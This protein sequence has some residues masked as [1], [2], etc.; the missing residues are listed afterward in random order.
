MGSK[1]S[2]PQKVSSTELGQLIG[3]V[4]LQ[5]IELVS[6]TFRADKARMEGLSNGLEMGT[7]IRCQVKAIGQGHFY[8][9]VSAVIGS[10]SKKES[11]DLPFVGE[12][13]WS[14]LYRT[15][16]QHPQAVIEAFVANSSLLHAWPYIREFTHSMTA[17]MG[18]PPLVL[19]LLVITQGPSQAPQVPPKTPSE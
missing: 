11:S 1:K 9:E 6:S 2:K 15:T 17:K 19:P 8:V 4:H 5:T 12:S 3:S 10:R 13:V 16:Q 7:S 14:I 18:L